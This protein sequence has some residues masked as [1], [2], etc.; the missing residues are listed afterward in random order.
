[1]NTTRTLA[2]VVLGLVLSTRALQG[3]DRW[4]YRDGQLGG[5]LPS[6]SAL[7]KVAASDVKTI[8]QRPAVTQGLAWFPSYFVTG[9]PAPQNGPDEHSDRHRTAGM[10]YASD[11]IDAISMA[12]GPSLKPAV[13]NTRTVTSQIE[14]KGVLPWGLRR[15]GA[16]VGLTVSGVDISI[17]RNGFKL[18]KSVTF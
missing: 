4:R 18:S 16:G 11:I 6:V 5:D 7:A 1:M 9:S 13:K 3:Q 2:I 10:T 12:Y 15:A 8:H 14:D 17:Q